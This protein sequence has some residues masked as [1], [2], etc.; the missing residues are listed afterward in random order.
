MKFSSSESSRKHFIG[1]WQAENRAIFRADFFFCILF[2]SSNRLDDI[3]LPLLI[4]GCYSI[5]VHS[6]FRMLYD[7][8]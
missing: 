1:R 5:T 3:T 8:G 6:R 2:Q 7:I 4:V